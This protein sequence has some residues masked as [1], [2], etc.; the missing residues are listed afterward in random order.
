M[1]ADYGKEYVLE[2]YETY[3]DATAASVMTV[4]IGDLCLSGT[5][6]KSKYAPDNYF[7]TYEYEG[8]DYSFSVDDTGRITACYFSRET[9]GNSLSKE[10]CVAVAED[11]LGNICS[12]DN[13]NAEVI[14]DSKH[15]EYDVVFTKYVDGLRTKDSARVSVGYDGVVKSFNSWM[16]GRVPSNIDVNKIDFG[17]VD[18][19]LLQKL[20]KIYANAKVKFGNIDYGEPY[21]EL[22]LLKDG[23]IG[24]VCLYKFDC[25]EDNGDYTMVYS[26]L[27]ELVVVID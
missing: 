19:S 25:L 8:V 10:K 27:M 9:M 7:P 1:I 5:F 2:D 15:Q 18:A 17:I 3:E 16:L 6:V 26:E 21:V 12:L 14:D 24:L 11:F 22:T 23:K 4:H 20:D 13:Y